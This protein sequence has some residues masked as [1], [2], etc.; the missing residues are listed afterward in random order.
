MNEDAYKHYVSQLQGRERKSYNGLLAYVNK[1]L[2]KDQQ[3]PKNFTDMSI[4]QDNI[5]LYTFLKGDHKITAEAKKDFNTRELDIEVKGVNTEHSAEIKNILKGYQDMFRKFKDINNEDAFN[6]R[7][8]KPFVAELEDYYIANLPDLL[9]N[10]V[11]KSYKLKEDGSFVSG[12]SE[13]IPALLEKAFDREQLSIAI[14]PYAADWVG[15]HAYVDPNN[16]NLQKQITFGFDTKTQKIENL[17]A[18]AQLQD[19]RKLHNILSES[20]VFDDPKFS[21]ETMLQVYE[22]YAESGEFGRLYEKMSNHIYNTYKNEIAHGYM[23]EMYGHT[24]VMFFTTDTGFYSLSQLLTE[25][26]FSYELDQKGFALSKDFK[27]QF[28]EWGKSEEHLGYN[29]ADWGWIS[30]LKG[31]AKYKGNL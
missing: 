28:E 11:S 1:F 8:F 25:K 14:A 23:Q 30:Y 12:K 15:V 9:Y 10:I 17:K 21:Q 18:G 26:E 3:L 6:T 7:I 22:K 20:G 16:N 4:P 27:I 19:P 31:Y 29:L 24:A 5:K 13:D 2:P